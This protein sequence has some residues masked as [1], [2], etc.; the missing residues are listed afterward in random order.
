MSMV[1]Q[2]ESDDIF[3]SELK[4]K[5]LTITWSSVLLFLFQWENKH[6][7]LI[8][9]GFLIF[10]IQIKISSDLLCP[11]ILILPHPTL[12]IIENIWCLP[13]M[14]SLHNII[15]IMDSTDLSTLCLQRATLSPLELKV[16]PRYLKLSSAFIGSAY[17]VRKFTSDFSP[18]ILSSLHLTMD[19]F[20]RFLSVICVIIL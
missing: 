5:K 20:S 18:S 9:M 6:V 10:G 7:G 13:K 11:T 16:S 2:S 3:V 12:T 14:I 17:T 15:S 8:T 4:A 19:S 1:G